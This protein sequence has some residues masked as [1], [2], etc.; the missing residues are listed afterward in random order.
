MVNATLRTDTTIVGS[1]LMHFFLSFEAVICVSDLVRLVDTPDISI[2][3][4][5]G[6]KEG[7]NINSSVFLVPE[8]TS[9]V[10]NGA[11]NPN[12]TIPCLSLAWLIF[13]RQFTEKLDD[14]ACTFWKFLVALLNLFVKC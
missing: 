5:E 7:A 8:I 14:R 2:H 12:H 13:R 4:V 3:P 1:Y 9:N 6:A 11:L 10:L